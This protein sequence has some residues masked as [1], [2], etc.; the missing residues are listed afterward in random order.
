M[1]KLIHTLSFLLF[2]S[3][4]VA[5]SLGAN[6]IKKDGTSITGNASNQLQVDTTKMA[7]KYYVSTAGG[8]GPT[9]PTGPTGAV[10]AT[11]SAGATGA[12]GFLSSGTTAGNT[13]YWNGTQWVLSSSNIFNN[14]GDVGIGTALPGFKL[15]VVTPSG[16]G[17]AVNNGTYTAS[18][19]PS[20]SSTLTEIN[21]GN[22]GFQLS[23]ADGYFR[24]N[25]VSAGP[26]LIY[27]NGGA[28]A[29]QLSGAVSGT[30]HINI[31]SVGATTISDLSG[32]GTRM[33]VADATGLLATQTI[34]PV[35]NGGT[36]VS[37]FGGTNRILYT[38]TTDNLSSITTANTSVLTTDGS[39]V[40]SWT[41]QAD[42]FNDSYGTTS[43]TV[44]QGN[45][46][47][48]LERDLSYYKKTGTATY[49]R[50]QT[51]A[52]M[53]TVPANSTA[54]AAN[55][56]RAT[57]FIVSKTTTYTAMGVEVITG[58]L[59]G[60]DFGVAIYDDVNGVPTNLIVDDITY[61]ANSATFQSKVIS[62]TLT[63]GLYW[64]AINHNSS[65][66]LVF[67][68]MSAASLPAVLG[69]PST[70]G[71]SMGGVIN[72][73]S[74][75]GSFPATFPTASISIATQTPATIAL[76]PQ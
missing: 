5:Q 9:G 59:L 72:V 61:N 4:A 30:P 62:E 35:A 33:V 65:V 57:P 15:H 71:A 10:G 29:L 53:V 12:T 11:G 20:G 63:P 40:P 75:F 48:F 17:I 64:L 32:T 69:V 52:V 37:T 25:R 38:T 50:W 6:G 34:L 2:T 13:T 28:N 41:G 60:D 26:A 27:V 31:S 70:L 24:L 76:K 3:I 44:V 55:I 1:K 73:P 46:S 18:L 68:G 56:I 39:G 22:I 36:G 19:L 42:A 43:G 47:R 49:E 54:V 51:S 66:S 45:D 67:R 23:S 74:T 58:G 21:T 8:I 16:G 7:T 14:G